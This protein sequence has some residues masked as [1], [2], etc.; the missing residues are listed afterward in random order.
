MKNSDFLMILSTMTSIVSLGF[1]YFDE[2]V[3]AA[4]SGVIAMVSLFVCLICDTI[5]TTASNEFKKSLDDDWLKAQIAVHS[6][7]AKY[8][9]TAAPDDNP[10]HYTCADCS[11]FSPNSAF[12]L[13]CHP[14]K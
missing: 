2:Y 11:H 1:L 6:M 14:R 13:N 9:P 7:P 10:W 8:K 12:C 4:T 5:E 3:M